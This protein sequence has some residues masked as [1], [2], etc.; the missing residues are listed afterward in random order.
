MPHVDAFTG[1]ARLPRGT[2]CGQCRGRFMRV[3]AI[4]AQY[5]SRPRMPLSRLRAPHRGLR[6][7]ALAPWPW[8]YAVF[9]ACYRREQ[10][11][12]HVFGH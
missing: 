4:L 6:A 12:N 3:P 9:W 1:G 11:A 8:S 7:Q 2:I 10:G 5:T